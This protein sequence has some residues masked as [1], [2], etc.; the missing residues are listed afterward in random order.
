MAAA[1]P[2]ASV[3]AA[4][5]TVVVLEPEPFAAPIVRPATTRDCQVVVD[6]A[7]GSVRWV[8]CIV[9]AETRRAYC[10]V[11]TLR[12]CIYGVVRHA[13]ALE[14]RDGLYRYLPDRQV[15]IKCMSKRLIAEQRRQGRNG[16]QEDPMN[17][18]AALQLLASPGHAHVQRLLECVEDGDTLYSICPFYPNGELYDFIENRRGE[19]RRRAHFVVQYLPSLHVMILM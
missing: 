4:G 13:V 17:E 18:L 10:F 16:I 6:E 5:S 9:S 19:R 2:A 3:A 1:A 12:E 8:R 15:A 14:E 7:R 11:R